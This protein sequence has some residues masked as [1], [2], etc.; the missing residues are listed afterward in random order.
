VV[1]RGVFPVSPSIVGKG[2]VLCDVTVLLFA[3]G[4]AWAGCSIV[5]HSRQGSALCAGVCCGDVVCNGGTV[6]CD[7]ALG[8][9][10]HQGDKAKEPHIAGCNLGF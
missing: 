8:I 10:P 9:G 5:S 3:G 6:C 4:A 2:T 7:D 1:Q